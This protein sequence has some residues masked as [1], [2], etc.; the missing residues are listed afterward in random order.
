M[1]LSKTLRRGLSVTVLMMAFLL[2]TAVCG[3]E[4]APTPTPPPSPSPTADLGDLLSR[5]GKKLDTMTTAKFKMVDETE[6][7]AKFL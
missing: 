6:S 5:A 4:S 3:T 7:G 1:N 2:L